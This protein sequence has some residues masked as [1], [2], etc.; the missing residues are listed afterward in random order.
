MIKI[1]I[2]IC[3]LRIKKIINIKIR[4]FIEETYIHPSFSTIETL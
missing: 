2:E 3:L 4:E 1:N